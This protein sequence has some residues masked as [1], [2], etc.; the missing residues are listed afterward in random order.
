MLDVLNDPTAQDRLVKIGAR[1]VPVL[2]N[3]DQHIFCQNLEDLA[4]FV[5][6]QG[7]GHTPL[8]PAELMTK[9]INVL[10]AAKRLFSTPPTA[11]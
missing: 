4:E 2:A 6:L 10:R 7:S 5:G 1:A 9:W 8:P 3:G 11:S